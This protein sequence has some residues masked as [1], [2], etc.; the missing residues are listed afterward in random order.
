MAK[1]LIIGASEFE[2]AP[3]R[4]SVA[5]TDCHLLVSGIGSTLSAAT[6]GN[7]LSS[8]HA[9]VGCVLFLGSC[10]SYFATLPI[11]AAVCCTRSTLCDG[12]LARGEGY[13][14]KLATREYEA[15]S[16][17]NDSIRIIGATPVVF[18]STTAITSSAELGEEIARTT[19]ARCENLE[20]FGVAAACAL[21]KLPWAAISIVTNHVGANAH[22]E[23][24]SNFAQAAD[25]T[26]QFVARILPALI[27]FR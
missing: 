1:P 20:L 14:P 26:A 13:L 11:G 3:L 4:G 8:H 5:E 17:I 21:Q 23:W 16:R 25:K 19:G 9:D 18:A 27:H 22:S 24:Q 6:V 10:G 15:S 2:L 7:W 12:A